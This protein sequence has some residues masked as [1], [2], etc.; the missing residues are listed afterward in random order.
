MYLFFYNIPRRWYVYLYYNNIPRRRY[1]YLYYNSIPRRRYVYAAVPK[2][3]YYVYN[4]NISPFETTCSVLFYGV[5]SVIMRDHVG[6]MVKL[7]RCRY[8]LRYVQWGAGMR[9]QVYGAAIAGSGNGVQVCVAG[10]GST[11]KVHSSCCPLRPHTT[12][13]PERK[14]TLGVLY[15]V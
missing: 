2:Y 9:I 10:S 12:P 13:F 15:G 8:S 14:S 6:N 5:V 3:Y 1:V 4:N 11:S 7:C